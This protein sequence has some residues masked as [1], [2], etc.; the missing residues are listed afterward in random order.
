MIFFCRW[1]LGGPW[2][3]SGIEGNSRWLRRVWHAILEPCAGKADEDTLKA[4]RRKAHQ[5]LKRVTYDYENFE[6][7]TIISRLMELLNEMQ[8]AKNAGAYGSPAWDETVDLYLRML[9]PVCPHIAEELWEKL[10]K[11][12]SIHLQPW[13]EVDEEAAKDELITLIV[14][15]NGKL[16]DRIEV[17]PHHDRSQKAGA[18]ASRQAGSAGSAP[19]EVIVV[20][21]DW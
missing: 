1:E 14:Q 11:P 8:R 3:S 18:V 15:V 12:Y 10:G 13:P 21:D 19:S 20:P 2:S 16:R 9:A 5:T 7:N 17:E 4:L 6:F